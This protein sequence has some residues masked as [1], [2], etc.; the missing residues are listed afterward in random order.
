[1]LE[2]YLKGI[3]NP[4]VTF[5]PPWGDSAKPRNEHIT[6]ITHT[7]PRPRNVA[8]PFALLFG[9]VIVPDT[10]RQASLPPSPSPWVDTVHVSFRPVAA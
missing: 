1:M 2:L 9:K 8:I 7:R 3:F 10:L 5:R 4:F 6:A